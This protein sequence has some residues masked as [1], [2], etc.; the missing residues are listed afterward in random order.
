MSPEEID[1]LRLKYGFWII[2]V[3]ALAAFIT[4]VWVPGI[5]AGASVASSRE[6]LPPGKRRDDPHR[7][8][9]PGHVPKY[10]QE[11]VQPKVLG[12]PHLQEH[13]QRGKNDR[14]YDS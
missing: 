7:V 10:R 8:D 14:E 13:T 5:S 12:Q 6:L 4:V 2:T 1:Q 3:F 11:Y 9:Q